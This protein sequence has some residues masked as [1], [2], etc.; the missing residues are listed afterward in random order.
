MR[1]AGHPY[2]PDG[3]LQGWGRVFV[4]RAQPELRRFAVEHVVPIPSARMRHGSVDPSG[5]KYER[6]VPLIPA[7][8]S[9]LAIIG[10][11][12][13]I[14]DGGTAVVQRRPANLIWRSPRPGRFM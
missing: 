9:G 8:Y 7:L 3:P 4:G 10:D 1:P 14:L 12:G 11:V 5:S 6:T 13:S 2:E